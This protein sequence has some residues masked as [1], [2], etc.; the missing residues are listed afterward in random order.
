VERN[1]EGGEDH[2]SSEKAIPDL[3]GESIWREELTDHVA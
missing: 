3:H 2:S 1:V